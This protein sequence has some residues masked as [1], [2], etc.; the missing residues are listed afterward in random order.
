VLL[1]EL[2]GAFNFIKK[3][4]GIINKICGAFLIVIGILMA[5]GLMTRVLRM[6]T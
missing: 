4:Y 3:H 1:S 2:K 6:L 5:T